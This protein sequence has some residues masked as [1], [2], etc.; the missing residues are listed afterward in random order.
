MSRTLSFVRE[1]PNVKRLFRHKSPGDIR[2]REMWCCIVTKSFG[3]VLGVI[4]PHDELDDE[5]IIMSC[6]DLVLTSQKIRNP[7]LNT[8]TSVIK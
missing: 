1:K 5:N 2:N 3:P 6:S 8:G 7:Y 4:F